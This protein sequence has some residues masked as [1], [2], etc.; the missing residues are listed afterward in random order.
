[1]T[2]KNRFLKLT[3]DDKEDYSYRSR[4]RQSVIEFS[5]RLGQAVLG[6]KSSA[7]VNSCDGSAEG[8]PAAVCE[9]LLLPSSH[10]PT[11][12]KLPGSSGRCHFPD[13]GFLGLY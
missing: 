2:H 11:H 9:S 8:Q 1:M 5:R 12:K 4:R 7:A 3:T 6:R 13:W 10:S